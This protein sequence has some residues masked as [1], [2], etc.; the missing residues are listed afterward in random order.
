MTTLYLNRFARALLPLGLITAPAFAESPTPLPD[1]TVEGDAADAHV[2]DPAAHA[3]TAPDIGALLKQAP[4]AQVNRNGALTGIAQYRGLYGDRVNVLVD[5]INIEA[6]CTNAMDPPLSHIPSAQLE[7]LTVIRG[8]APVSSGLETLGGTIMAESSIGTFGTDPRFETHGDLSSSG[9]SVN[10]SYALSGLGWLS[11]QQHKLYAA[12]SRET[13][14]DA[15]FADGTI[16][17]TSY[18]RTHYALGYGMRFGT[19]TLALDLARNEA[20][21]SGTPSLPM[22]IVTSTTDTAKLDWRGTWSGTTLHAQLSDAQSDHT[23]DN[24]SLRTPPGG[25]TRRAITDAS[26]VGYRVDAGFGV[27]SGTLTLG[28]DGHMADHNAVVRDPVNNPNLRVV[29]FNDVQRDRYGAFGEWNGALPAGW[30]LDLGLRYTRVEMNAGAVD[31]S[32][33][34]MNAGV[35]T[36]ED[37]FNNADRAR[38]DNNID[39]VAQLSHALGEQTSLV[40][41]VAR[42]VRSPSYQERYLWLPM[43]ATAGLA[44]GNNYVGDIGLDPE[45]SHQ[46]ELGVDWRG[47]HAYVSPRAFYRDVSNYI[48][49]TPATDPTV[50]MVSSGNGDATPLQFSNVDATLYGIDTTAGVHFGTYWSIDGVLSYVRGER[51][52]VSD[53]LYRVYPLSG[54]L[55][56]KYARDRW[57]LSGQSE[58]AARQDKVSSTNSETETAGYAVF[59]VF[60]DV[61]LG[62]RITLAAGVANLFDTLYREH[63]AGINRALDSDVALGDRIPGYGRNAY[64]RLRYVW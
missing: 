21:D 26:G 23:M 29:S 62:S 49:G 50:I 14:N 30:G 54:T 27:A 57:S 1:V 48:Q 53:N 52:D 46:V 41:G 28:L 42:K 13:G 10:D 11:N 22:D 40:G 45:V 64:A 5:G 51:D 58:F 59:N 17:P 44:D 43:E 18:E 3:G 38:N 31:H 32:M 55:A 35:T 61:K 7:S 34:G 25:N 24:Y 63:T 16:R 56:V 15:D 47:T 20:N 39:W 36:L 8:I 2:I 60:G 12:A 6:S 33:Y 4:G 9:A 37:R 19:Q